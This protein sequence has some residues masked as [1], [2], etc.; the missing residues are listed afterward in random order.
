MKIKEKKIIEK[1]LN[2][3]AKVRHK[4]V[5]IKIHDPI[6]KIIIHTY[7]QQINTLGN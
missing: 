1:N 5:R 6:K 3:T 2:V 7:L 4:K